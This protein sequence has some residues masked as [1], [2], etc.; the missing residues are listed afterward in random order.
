MVRIEP[1]ELRVAPQERALVAG[2]ELLETLLLERSQVATA[3]FRLRLDLGK[4]EPARLA[5]GSQAPPEIEHSPA[6]FSPRGV[7]LLRAGRNGFFYTSSGPS[8]S[9]GSS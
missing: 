8:S 7:C 2:R 9:R 1:Q 4:L 5:R 6:T 3:E